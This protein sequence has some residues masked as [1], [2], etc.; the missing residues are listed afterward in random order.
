MCRNIA[1]SKKPNEIL[2]RLCVGLENLFETIKATLY[3]LHWRCGKSINQ[4]IDILKIYESSDMAIRILNDGP[5]GSNFFGVLYH[6]AFK[7]QRDCPMALAST[8]PCLGC[9]RFGSL[10]IMFY[11]SSNLH[12]REGLL[13]LGY[14]MLQRV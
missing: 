13:G 1:T 8:L 6:R 5:Y 14:V 2:L 10:L 7:K 9:Q 4:D 11:S 12:I 3:D